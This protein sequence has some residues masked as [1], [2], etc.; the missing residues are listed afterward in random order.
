[1]KLVTYRHEDQQDRLGVLVDDDQRVVDCASA[2]PDEPVLTSMQALMDA[3]QH[4]LRIVRDLAHS[5][6][7]IPL[8]DVRLRPPVPVPAQ[9]RDCMCFEEHLL[10]SFEVGK[11][12]AVNLA[13]DPEAMRR[14]VEEQGLF[15][16]PEA[17][18][19]QPL[20]YK[21]NR[22]AC[23]GHDDDVRWPAY[24]SLIDY[25]LELAC[26][27]GK[28]GADIPKDRAA[29]HIFGYSIFND[30]SA[31]DAQVP[32]VSAGMGPAK[33]K[34]F[35]GANAIGPCIVTADAI[36]PDNLTMIARINGEERSRGS[37]STMYWKFADVI[38]H[39]SQSETLH[40]GEMI[41]SGTVGG[42]CGLEHEQF[43]SIGDVVELEIEGI[44][45]L[46]NRVVESGT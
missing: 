27:I 4:G 2:L 34:D 37:S 13:A 23:S 41:G 11:K 17:W 45:S 20:Y 30:F 21:G 46:R 19:S 36:D 38:A 33:G 16:V 26:W 28:T 10:R 35:D 12:L 24:S 29:E 18:Y 7:S 8:A 15:D 43:L 6:P 31:R 39:A 42:G 5:V 9:V 40:A 22:F 32:E 1:M 3:G 25:E 14:K 44:G